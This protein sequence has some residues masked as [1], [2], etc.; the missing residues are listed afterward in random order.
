MGPFTYF[1]S[2]FT[3]RVIF[4]IIRSKAK[5][6]KF[7]VNL[8]LIKRDDFFLANMDNLLPMQNMLDKRKFR[9]RCLLTVQPVLLP[10][11]TELVKLHWWPLPDTE[12]CLFSFVK[13]A[14]WHAIL[15]VSLACCCASADGTSYIQTNVKLK[16]YCRE[17]CQYRDNL[18]RPAS[19][20]VRAPYSWFGGH[21]FCNRS[22]TEFS[23]KHSKQ[24]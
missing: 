2:N 17:L 4:G 19:P 8:L 13:L 3:T 23:I 21:E 12:H 22:R 24:S 18:K 1:S 6:L 16:G 7:D 20:L 15:A 14:A 10:S 5:I 9:L 11:G